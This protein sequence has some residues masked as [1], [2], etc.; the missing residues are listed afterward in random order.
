MVATVSPVFFDRVFP[1][2]DDEPTTRVLAVEEAINDTLL[3]HERAMR[4]IV[5]NAIEMAL[6]ATNDG[7]H[8]VGRRQMV[9][10]AAVEPLEAELDADVLRRL[11]NAVAL[12]IGPE[13]ILAARDI[14]GLTP[15]ET[16][17]VTRW[18]A[19]ALVAGALAQ[20]ERRKPRPSGP[21]RK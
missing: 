2:V 10:G 11:R 14:C 5:R 9:I 16:R 18:A 6:A 19:E 15:D 12:V 8:R 17:D 20:G 21:F 7:P 3:S 13:A 4:V 1:S